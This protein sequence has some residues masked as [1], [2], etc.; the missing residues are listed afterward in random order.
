MTWYEFLIAIIGAGGIGGLIATIANV[1][2]ARRKSVSEQKESKIEQTK[3]TVN[4]VDELL[5]K[6]LKWMSERMDQGE[7]VRKQE[8]EAIQQ[9][10]GQQLSNIQDENR[11]QNETIAAQN[12]RIGEQND[13]LQDI[14][15]YLNG[16]FAAFEE[17]KA[18]QKKTTKKTKKA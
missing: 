7:T 9:N 2:Q 4:L 5:Q 3:E 12:D 16:G 14:K 18:A 15:E 10:L 1:I 11:K 6:Q 8:L 17:R 13:L